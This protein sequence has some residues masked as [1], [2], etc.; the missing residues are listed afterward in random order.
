[1]ADKTYF[2]NEETLTDIANAIR[3]KDGT[4]TPMTASEMP[5]RINNIS[6]GLNEYSSLTD[7]DVNLTTYPSG[8]IGFVSTTI[9][10]STTSSKF[11]YPGYSVSASREITNCTAENIR[12]GI[13]I[14]GVTGTYSGTPSY[15]GPY[16]YLGTLT[17]S[18]YYNSDGRIQTSNPHM[19]IFNSALPNVYLY[20]NGVTPGIY[21]AVSGNKT[22]LVYSGEANML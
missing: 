15:N 19:I 2:I 14:A 5:T 3:A 7:S 4:S 16:E 20:G 21:G 12:S 1:M 17:S 9:M 22:I 6:T 13:T 10:N 8:G 18:G 11:L